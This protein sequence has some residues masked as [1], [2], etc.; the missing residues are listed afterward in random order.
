MNSKFFS[1]LLLALMLL[2]AGCVNLKEESDSTKDWSAE[3][4]YQEAKY[5]QEQGNFEEAISYLEKLEA[6]YPYGNYA[7]QAQLDVAY[8][9]YKDNEPTLAL[10][11]TER[12][13]R[14]HPT[15]PYVDYAYYLKGLIYFNV[16]RGA[17]DFLLGKNVDYS[18]RDSKAMRDALIA[19]QDLVKRFPDSKYAP[20]AHQRIVYLVNL[21]AKYEIH[22]ARHYYDLDAYVA[23]V[24]RCKY[25]L[26]NYQQ[27]PAVEDALGIMSMAY[28]KMGY[29]ELMD[30]ALRVLKLNFPDS[31]YFKRI[32]R[33]KNGEA[34]D[35]AG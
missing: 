32:A 1:T 3:R 15:H 17:F 18:D 33:M 8:I 21:M 30:D 26:E 34:K 14:L 6:R 5:Q 13:I 2:S 16:K 22:V 31:G 10:A 20:D 28:M 4:L 9:Y 19:F 11:A 7:A 25:V 27:T 35:D 12:F 23:T 29:T 24:N